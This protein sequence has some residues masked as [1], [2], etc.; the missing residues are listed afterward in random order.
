[1]SIATADSAGSRWA[2]ELGRNAPNT[3]FGSLNFDPKAFLDVRL[4]FDPA[5]TE[6]LLDA[7]RMDP[8]F[9]PSFV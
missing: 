1:M 9:E 2:I 4:S 3:A 5:R 6:P 7:K 8:S